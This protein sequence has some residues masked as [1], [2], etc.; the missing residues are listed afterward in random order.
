M[1]CI[2]SSPLTFDEWKK[3][4][5]KLT[6]EEKG[7]HLECDKLKTNIEEKIKELKENILFQSGELKKT[8]DYNNIISNYSDDTKYKLYRKK[9][10]ENMLYSCNTL[11]Y[12]KGGNKKKN[13]TRR[14]NQSKRRKTNN[15]KTRK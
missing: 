2:M 12:V 1:Y 10:W 7:Q 6:K 9:F 3:K 11:K 4:K 15:R 13:K 5:N 8:P 14:P